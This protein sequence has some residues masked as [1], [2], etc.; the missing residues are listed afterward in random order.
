MKRRGFSPTTRTFQT[1]FMGLSRIEDWS[2]HSKQ[3]DNARSVYDSFQRHMTS[4]KKDDSASAELSVGPL[5]AY[6]KI[7][8]NAGYYQEL[9]DVYYAMDTEGPLAPD[10]F[11]Y[12]AIFQALSVSG[13][14][15]RIKV[16]AD[17]KLLWNQMQ[18]ASHKSPGFQIDAFLITSALIA[19][20]RGRPADQSLAFQIIR[21]Y[22]GLTTPDD[23]PS[24]GTIPLTPQSF[25]AVLLLCSQSEKYH[26]CD[27]F[28]L[29]VKKRPEALGGASIL[30]RAHLEEV[31]KAR[32]SLKDSGTALYCLELLEWMLREEITGRSGPKIRPALST[33][34]VVLTAC[35]RDADWRS[36][37]RTFDLM[38]GY[39]SHDFMDGA[40]SVTPRL[41]KRAPG[42]N[43]VPNAETLSTLV[44]TALA[45]H[46]RAN[47]RQCLRIVGYLGVDDLFSTKE[48]TNDTKKSAKNRAFYASKLAS[49]VIEAVAKVSGGGE[50]AS[51]DE[52]TQWNDLVNRAKERIKEAPRTEFIPSMKGERSRARLTHY[53]KIL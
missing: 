29:Q 33:Y 31:L 53:E 49:A 44:R 5:A 12:T 41:D 25:A 11:V 35:W 7:L 3:L 21:D 1:M 6:I 34:N 45:S 24:T 15:D 47:V 28:L 10:Q 9:F 8:G 27:H 37:A 50:R 20:S 2:T 51:Q 42:R 4:V 39:H 22:F 13:K 26:L 36:A 30:D 19:L 48:T 32:L 38:T 52:V 40:V 16:S 14:Q 43:L 23:P 46:S 18:K 17:A